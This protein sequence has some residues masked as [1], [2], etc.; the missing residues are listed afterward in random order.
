MQLSFVIFPTD[1][2]SWPCTNVKPI[3]KAAFTLSLGGN[4]LDWIKAG[5]KQNERK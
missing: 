2:L 4:Y 5:M 3:K 1:V